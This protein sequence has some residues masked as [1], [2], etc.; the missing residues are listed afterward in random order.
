MLFIRVIAPLKDNIFTPKN[1]SFTDKDR[2]RLLPLQQDALPAAR[3]L[4]GIW[5][6]SAIFPGGNIS[7]AEMHRVVE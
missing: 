5:S 1:A 6:G 7:E 2:Q 3:K 4:Q